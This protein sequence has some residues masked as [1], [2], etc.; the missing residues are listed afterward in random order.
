MDGGVHTRADFEAWAA[1][2]PR[3]DR[4]VPG[5][6]HALFLRWCATV[7]FAGGRIDDRA[8]ELSRGAR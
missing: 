5:Y 7:L 2:Q 8:C 1:A 3:P 6:E 4:I